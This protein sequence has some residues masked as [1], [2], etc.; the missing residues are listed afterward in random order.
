[1]LKVKLY[2]VIQKIFYDILKYQ[3]LLQIQTYV[4][5]V[6]KLNKDL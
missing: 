6:T 4:Y 2:F 3:W 5:C 1:M